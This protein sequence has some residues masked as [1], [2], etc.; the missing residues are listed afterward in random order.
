VGR[1]R[2]LRRLLQPSRSHSSLRK[3]QE[4]PRCIVLRTLWGT[5]HHPRLW[6]CLLQDSDRR[7]HGRLRLF[8]RHRGRSRRN[9]CAAGRLVPNRRCQNKDTEYAPA[10]RKA[11]PSGGRTIS[12]RTRSTGSDSRVRA[13]I[14][15]SSVH[16]Q[17]PGSHCARRAARSASFCTTST[18]SCTA[19][20][21]PIVRPDLARIRSQR[22]GSS[23]GRREA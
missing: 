12:T 13:H 19:R 10:R 3:A 22:S 11:C 7:R 14:S 16:I 21:S 15:R 17:R 4:D 18:C 1:R 9:R 23:C 20:A 8:Q 5:L 2:R 6:F